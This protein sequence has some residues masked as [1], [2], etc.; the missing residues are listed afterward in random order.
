MAMPTNFD[1][2]ADIEGYTKDGNYVR[3]VQIEGMDGMRASVLTLGARLLDLRMP[4]GRPLVLS[5]GSVPEVEADMAYVGVAVGR[6]ANRIR[7]G[8]LCI[9]DVSTKLETNEQGR[10][11]IHGGRRAWDKRLFAVT[12]RRKNA[13][14]LF[15]FSPDGDQGYP[16]SVEVRVR[17]ELRGNGKL[18]ISLSTTNVGSAPT[19][20]NMTVSL[21]HHS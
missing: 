20:T 21:Q 10:N 7:G 5:F 17:Y 9:D 15:L 4:D 11:H 16:S 14:E 19:I 8:T 2:C 13:V 6:T 3:T 1:A 18:F 12:E